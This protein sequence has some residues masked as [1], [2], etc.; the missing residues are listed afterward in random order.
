[1]EARRQGPLKRRNS[2]RKGMGEGMLFGACQAWVKGWYEGVAVN[3][4]VAPDYGGPCKPG[5]DAET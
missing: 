3:V 1:M 4:Q 2:V 5:R